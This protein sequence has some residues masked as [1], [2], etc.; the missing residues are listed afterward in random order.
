MDQ[1][2]WYVMHRDGPVE[3]FATLQKVMWAGGSAHYFFAFLIHGLLMLSM[4]L[5]MLVFA[6]R[7]IVLAALIMVGPIAWMVFPIRGIGPQWVV[8][9]WSAVIV[10]LLTGPL[11]IGFLTL[12]ISGLST[13]KTIWDPQSWPMLVGLVLV[14]FAPFA[15]FGLFSFVGGVAAD[16]VGS[17]AASRAGRLAA[18]AGRTA[19]SVP[20]R[21]HGK[22]A[23]APSLPA[24]KEA[25]TSASTQSTVRGATAPAMASSTSP[26]NAAGRAGGRTGAR[27]SPDPTPSTQG[28]GSSRPAPSS[29]STPHARSAS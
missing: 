27:S 10:L 14:A 4:L 6:F 1:L 9:Y 17:G 7:N 18:S 16:S 28:G 5:L 15:V 11:T 12:I 2:T 13:V 22:P 25:H 20:S 19:I 8:Q 3:L 26:S 24:A 21:L 29:P 23:H